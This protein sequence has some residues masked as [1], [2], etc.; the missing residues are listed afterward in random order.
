M[1][2]VAT[3]R[4]ITPAIVQKLRKKSPVVESVAVSLLEAPQAIPLLVKKDRSLTSYQAYD[5]QPE[6]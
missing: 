5:M 1:A 4:N 2:T 6:Q 3:R